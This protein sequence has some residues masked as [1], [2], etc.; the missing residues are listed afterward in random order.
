[1]ISR[2]IRLRITLHRFLLF[3]IHHQSFPLYKPLTPREGDVV[4]RLL[5]SATHA[6]HLLCNSAV[7][8]DYAYI[9]SSTWRLAHSVLDLTQGLS[10]PSTS[11]SP[12][13]GSRRLFMI[14]ILF[15]NLLS[16]A[17]LVQ[18]LKVLYYNLPCSLSVFYYLC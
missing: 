6:L 9:R 1:M 3:C 13:V 17:L 5:S 18:T 16:E 11:K 15:Q 4:D 12:Q 8:H 14:K 2:L 10:N 7:T